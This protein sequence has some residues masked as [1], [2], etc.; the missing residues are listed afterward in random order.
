M[1]PADDE[2]SVRE[3]AECPHLHDQLDVDL[4][5]EHRQLGVDNVRAMLVLPLDQLVDGLRHGLEAFWYSER[6]GALANASHTQPCG[7][8][9]SCPTPCRTGRR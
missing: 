2:E 4:L 3:S 8:G 1:I 6:G 7:L 9:W 5:G